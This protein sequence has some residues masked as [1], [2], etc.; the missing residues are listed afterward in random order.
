MHLPYTDNYPAAI[1][2]ATDCLAATLGAALWAQRLPRPAA[3]AL[4]L[5]GIVTSAL[6]VH[7]PT[8]EPIVG[9]GMLPSAEVWLGIGTTLTTIALFWSGPRRLGV[10]AAVGELLLIALGSWVKASNDE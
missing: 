7:A 8:L 6:L 9:H 2:V 10:L 3:D 5:A 4:F 1:S